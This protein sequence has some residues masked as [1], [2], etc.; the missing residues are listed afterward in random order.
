MDNDT[1][2]FVFIVA[3]I[4]VGNVVKHM[5]T[6]GHNPQKAGGGNG[7]SDGMFDDSEMSSG[8]TFS[9]DLMFNPMY[10]SLPMNIYHDHTHDFDSISGSIGSDMFSD[11]FGSSDSIG[12]GSSMFED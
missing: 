9:D 8:A 12:I 10:N 6:A 5:I 3:I 2:A 4:A 1:I 7:N 11:S